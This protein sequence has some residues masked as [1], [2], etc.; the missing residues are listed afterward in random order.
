MGARAAW[1]LGEWGDLEAFVH[2]EHM[3]SRRHKVEDLE[4]VES[5]LVLEAVV[6]TQH[7]KFEEVSQLFVSKSSLFYSVFM[8]VFVSV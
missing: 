8:C 3:Q 7:D 2:G 6:A 4:G 1:A 5:C